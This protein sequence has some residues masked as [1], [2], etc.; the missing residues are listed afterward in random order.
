[1]WCVQVYRP[2]VPGEEAGGQQGGAGAF[3]VVAD[4]DRLRELLPL[5]PER[6]TVLRVGAE[7]F[8]AGCAWPWPVALYVCEGTHMTC[9]LERGVC[10][11]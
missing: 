5:L 11:G 2:P 10:C 6:D 9:R 3:S 1:M 4:A 8:C 7:G